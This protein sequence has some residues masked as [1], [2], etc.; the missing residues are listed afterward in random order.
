VEIAC[1]VEGEGE[2]Q[3]LPLLIRRIVAE[4]D[5]SLFVRVSVAVAWPKSR[6]VKRDRLNQ[7]VD[8]AARGLTGPGALLILVD[9]DDDCP[10]DLGPRLLRWASLAR[11][12]LPVAAVVANREYEA[13]FLAAAESLRGHR[14]LVDEIEAPS[15][16][17]GVA[18]AK[19][20]LSLSRHF[21]ARQPYSPTRH[22]ASF[23]AVFDLEL[24]RRRAPSFEKLCRDVRRLVDAMRAGEG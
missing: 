24:A 5:P 16:P 18:G 22:Q 3:A 1:I 2:K 19:E 13:W 8:I 4:I 11:S 20:S 17:E 10:A 12:D 9:A 21:R 14:E 7:A 6:I 15:D 23:S